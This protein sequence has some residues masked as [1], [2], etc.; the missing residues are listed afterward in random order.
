[1]EADH[2]VIQQLKLI[3]NLVKLLEERFGAPVTVIETHISTL[4]L[5]GDRAFKIKK[6]VDCGFLD[7]TSL[8][9]RHFYCREELRLNGRLAPDLYRDVVAIRG[10]AD[11]PQLGGGAQAIEYMVE[12]ARFDEGK[13]LD[14]LL[15]HE[16]L[17]VEHYDQL[18]DQIA[19]FH[20][21]APSANGGESYAQP[22]L[23][24][25]AVEDNFRQ[26][27]PLNGMLSESARQHVDRL[28]VW[29]SEQ[30][31]SLSMLMQE[32]LDKGFVRECH[33]DLHLGNIV[34][35]DDRAIPFDGIEFNDAFRWIDVISDLSFLLMDLHY[36]QQ[37]QIAFHLLNRYLENTGDFDGVQLLAY[38][39]VYRAMI[40][41]KVALLRCAQ[42]EAGSDEYHMQQQSAEHHIA[43]AERLAHQSCSF[44]MITHGV[45][46][47]GK[48]W[49]SRQVAE[50]YGAIRIRS[51]VE[52]LRRNP[53]PD[54]RYSS[55]ATKVVYDT[56]HRYG[57]ALVQAGWS[58]I[59]DAAYL[60]R[61]ERVHARQV[62]ES[63]AC[64]YLILD[65]HCEV[66]ELERRIRERIREGR[67]PSEA[68]VTI[69]HRQLATEEPLAADEGPF[70]LHL[71]PS[72]DPVVRLQ[73]QLGAW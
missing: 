2:S 40:R 32:R 5:A 13:T 12:M 36:R 66:E 18:A 58:V 19:V 69:L 63:S 23:V 71:E 45:S 7:F 33:G 44:L 34:L 55:E 73:D 42:L 53:Q 20:H 68:D 39:Q 43:L 6:P 51:D 3:G 46:G 57:G 41:T 14:Q 49:A 29:S 72:S 1:M 37:P 56:L 4:L 60:R 35:L 17:T 70:V 11:Q 65:M 61:G 10:T 30:N 59:L 54:G 64:R 47:S 28:S 52:S 50:Q 38:Y 26:I 27:T 9:R 48:S 24:R 31:Q 8:E 16:Y 15:D 21:S 25:T 62:A 67:D 22:S